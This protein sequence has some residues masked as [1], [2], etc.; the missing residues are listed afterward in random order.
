MLV[1]PG[2]GGSR[3]DTFAPPIR[4]SGPPSLTRWIGVHL[5][6]RAVC[7]VCDGLSF[8]GVLIDFSIDELRSANKACLGCS[9]PGCSRALAN[10][11]A[12]PEKQPRVEAEC[13]FVNRL[14]EGAPLTNFVVSEDG[15]SVKVPYVVEEPVEIHLMS[16]AYLFDLS[17]GG[18]AAGTTPAASPKLRQPTVCG[19][20]QQ[21]AEDGGPCQA[22]TPPDEGFPHPGPGGSTTLNTANVTSDESVLPEVP[23]EWNTRHE[24]PRK[25]AYADCNDRCFF[26]TCPAD[27][28]PEW[29]RVAVVN[30]LDGVLQRL[31]S[32]TNCV[33]CDVTRD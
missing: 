20:P 10:F 11:A 13:L 28:V 27:V 7:R 31:R 22:S 29:A 8:P 32:S 18:S 3:Q 4:P 1:C 5:E 16:A 25:R 2:L 6:P 14:R 24:E 26:I 9:C 30:Q 19:E 12:A 33:G 23:L 15:R 17:R 21:E